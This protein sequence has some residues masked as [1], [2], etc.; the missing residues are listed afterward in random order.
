M[1][2]NNKLSRT[3]QRLEEIRRTL[4]AGSGSEDEF[5]PV[6]SE[7]ERA[8]AYAEAAHLGIEPR[9]VYEAAHAMSAADLDAAEEVRLDLRATDELRACFDSDNILES[10]HSTLTA[11]FYPAPELL[12]LLI[13]RLEAVFATS[14]DLDT[15]LLG[16]GETA[17][18]WTRARRRRKEEWQIAKRVRK[19][20]D[21][22]GACDPMRQTEAIKRVLAELEI[23][24]NHKS[25]ATRLRRNPLT[26]ELIT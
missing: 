4:K 12:L 9:V 23:D 6:L 25:M 24:A 20:M 18:S 14:I 13:E 16:P 15:A 3:R 1:S 26:R 11:G 8:W 19:Y 21:G 22:D 17:A 2:Q 5:S 7:L 10:L